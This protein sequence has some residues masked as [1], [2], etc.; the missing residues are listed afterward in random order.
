M[1]RNYNEGHNMLLTSI[2]HNAI[3][4]LELMVEARDLRVF[5]QMS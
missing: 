3:I 4:T 1:D 2:Y 5:H